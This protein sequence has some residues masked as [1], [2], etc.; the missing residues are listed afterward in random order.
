M[1]IFVLFLVL[2]YPYMKSEDG[3]DHFQSSTNLDVHLSESIL[4][5][6]FLYTMEYWASFWLAS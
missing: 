6:T 4:V 2:S 5:S 3:E 1:N